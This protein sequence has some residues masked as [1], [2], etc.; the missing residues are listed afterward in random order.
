MYWFNN[1]YDALFYF[2]NI[3]FYTL[4]LVIKNALILDFKTEV[5][6]KNTELVCD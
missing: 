5:S 3:F 1:N 6:V 2:L 4:F